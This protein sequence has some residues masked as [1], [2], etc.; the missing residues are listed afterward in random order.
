VSAGAVQPE[1]IPGP[2]CGSPA[3]CAEFDHEHPHIDDVLAPLPRR[4]PSVSRLVEDDVPD[5]DEDHV[6]AGEDFDW[7]QR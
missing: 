2:R 7:W 4:T 5:V 6:D 1:D 3:T